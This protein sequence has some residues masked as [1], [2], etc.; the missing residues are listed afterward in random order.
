MARS[1]GQLGADY[2][3]EGAVRRDGDKVRITAELIEAA[4]AR[5]LWAET[6]DRELTG[7][8]SVQDEVTRE[9]IGR[10]VARLT[11]AELDRGRS[12]PPETL[13]AY[14]YCLRGKALIE[15]RRGED[16]GAM[17]GEGR[18]LFAKAVEA[19]P[20][21]AP[22]IEGLA[23]SYVIAWLEPTGYEP[24]RREFH[25][26]STLDRAREL[27]QRAV[28]LDPYLASGHATLAWILHWQYRRDEA[29]TVFER[30]MQLNPNLMDGRFGLMLAHD[31]RAA[32]AIRFLDRAMRQDP[33]PP[34]IYLSYLGNSYYLAGDYEAARRTLIAAAESLPDYRPISTWLAAAAAQSGHA[35]EARA[36]AAKILGTRPN[37]TIAAV[38][39]HIR[40]GNRRDAERLVEG[41]RKAGLPE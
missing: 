10:L 31:G 18:Q 13:A 28:E 27:A 34:A 41:L 9:I 5:Q 22:A 35:D 30:A 37:F 7:I 33:F 17:V 6:Y 26:P 15:T 12:K 4:T 21:Y 11:R 36:A 40:L 3:V 1:G 39:E 2:L 32:E 8:F 25:D 38:L 14:D 20:H 29:R 24:L 16:R 23:N 19:D